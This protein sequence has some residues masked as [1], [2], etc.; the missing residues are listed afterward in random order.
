MIPL[1]TVCKVLRTSMSSMKLF[2][3]VRSRSKNIICPC[4]IN[5]SDR[6][7]LER[8]YNSEFAILSLEK[9]R[10]KIAIIRW[11]DIQKI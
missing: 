5:S 6:F 7:V 9:D 10:G 8:P 2:E 3:S 4:H 1:G 11:Q